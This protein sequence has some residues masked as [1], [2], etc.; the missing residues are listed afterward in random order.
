MDIFWKYT[1]WKYAKEILCFYLEH[2]V[3]HLVRYLFYDG[4]GNLQFDE[5]SILEYSHALPSE[6][7]RA[8]NWYYEVQHYIKSTNYVECRTS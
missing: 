4:G 2:I 3:C 5:I 1:I 8:S 6:L 7:D